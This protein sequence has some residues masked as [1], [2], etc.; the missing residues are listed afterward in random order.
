MLRQIMVVIITPL[1]CAQTYNKGV[2]IV[3]VITEINTHHNNK[4]S[5]RIKTNGME[6]KNVIIIF[7]RRNIGKIT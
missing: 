2:R 1:G 6:H 4:S 3:F 5:N 7:N